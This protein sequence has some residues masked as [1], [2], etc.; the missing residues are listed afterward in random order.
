MRYA[1]TRS[2]VLANV[3]FRYTGSP[4]FQKLA[5]EQL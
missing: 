3:L 1:F 5:C 4:S 2:S